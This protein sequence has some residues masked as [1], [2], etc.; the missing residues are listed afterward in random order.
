M[1]RLLTSGEVQK[2]LKVDRTTIYRMAEQGRLPAIK[3]GK[4]W[5][6]PAEKIEAWLRQRE[7]GTETAVFPT[8]SLTP[9][10]EL[11]NL[12]PHA[13]VKIIL[14]T[15]AELLGVML[16]ITD[17][18]GNPVTEISHPSGLFRFLQQHPQGW[19][20]CLQ[21]WQKL[22][23]EIE[24][25]PQFHQTHLNLLYARSLIRIGNELKGMVIAGCIAPDQWPPDQ[26]Q[27]EAIARE[28]EIS[29][30]QL[31]PHLSEVYF[32]TAE[33]RQQVLTYLQ[34]IANIMAHIVNERKELVERLNTIAQLAVL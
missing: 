30:D 10:T 12:L 14:D 11:A 23:E 28:L 17:L 34:R 1:E 22:G 19:Q 2:I 15:F 20:N 13:C 5:R 25:D 6:F 3:V 21:S 8:P 29:P 16:V 18:K 24:L 7:R 26:E 33:Q 9:T 4:Q 32:L 27:I 31:Q